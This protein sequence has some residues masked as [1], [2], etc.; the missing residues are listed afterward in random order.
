MF[1]RLKFFQRWLVWLA[2]AAP[3][4]SAAQTCPPEPDVLNKEQLLTLMKNA[5]DRGFLWRIEKDW[6]VGHLY[7]SIHFGKQA[8]M[9][10]GPK[11]LA[12]LAAAEVVALEIDVL[13]PAIQAQMAESS[14]LTGAAGKPL[15]LPAA[16]QKRLDALARKVCAPPEALAKQHPL[17]QLITVTIF[18]ARFLQ[19]EAAYGSEVFLSGYARGAGKTVVS[20]ETVESQLRALLAGEPRDIIEGL[21]RALALMERG[22]ARPV[23]ERLIAAWAGSNLGEL[24]NYAQWCECADSAA[25]RRALARLNDERNPGLAAGIDKLMRGGKNVFAAVGALHM[26]GPKALPKLLQE[27]GYQVEPVAFEPQ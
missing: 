19:L 20:L 8:W 11:T 25:D 3:L 23:T 1:I 22:R 21:D 24:Q 6:R 16:L 13:D 7:G 9:I 26:V 12:A 17:L 14:R 5:R 18:D 27:M 4:V 2:L 10:P 15:S